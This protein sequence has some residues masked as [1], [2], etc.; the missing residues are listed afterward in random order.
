M[1]IMTLFSSYCF[2]QVTVQ[3]NQQNVNINLPVIEKTVY[4]DKYRVV[5]VDKPQPKRVARKLSA[6]IQLLGYLWVY[7]EDLGDFKQPPLGVIGS[8]N[9][10]NPYGRDNWRIPTADELA[11]L[12]N[13]AAKVGLG[14]DIYLA[15]DHRN[16]VLRLVSTGLT[17]AQASTE[18]QSKKQAA[19]TSGKGVEIDGIVWATGNVDAGGF[20]T[21]HGSYYTWYNAQNACPSGW[22]LPTKQEL[23]N[24]TDQQK[25][26][27]PNIPGL[28]YGYK[29]KMVI[30]PLDSESFRKGYFVSGDDKDYY[31]SG[32]TPGG[33]YSRDYWVTSED[34]CYVLEVSY[35]GELKFIGEVKCREKTKR[36]FC[37][38]VLDN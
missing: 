7:P 14:D 22:R 19:I 23:E 9:A 27:G 30:L 2:A 24:L 15:T 36:G 12:E 18:K 34:Y 29:D 28:G 20:V 16:G 3:Q 35:L 25:W 37:R 10:Q 31:W 21:G 5:Y 17:N 11:V 8:L 38:C 32:T 1:A 13:N 6:P 4:V 26:G 33:Y